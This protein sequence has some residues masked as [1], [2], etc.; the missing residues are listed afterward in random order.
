MD[1]FSNIYIMD[2][3]SNIY[4]MDYFSTI[5]L[6]VREFVI[7]NFLVSIKSLEWKKTIIKNNILFYAF[8]LV[9]FF[10]LKILFKNLDIK[11]IYL[12]D[13]LYFSNYCKGIKILPI[14]ILF[15]GSSENGEKINLLDYFK[16]YS[17]SVPLWFF[18]ENEQLN[19]DIIYVKYFS[20]GKMVE[21]EIMVK[22]TKEELLCDIL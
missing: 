17:S 20:K 15:N 12:M 1:Y 7:K 22:D 6:S 8:K 18:L 21:K 13:N 14:L 11:C 10:I 16:Y 5:F 19:I 4:I 2:Y 9:P 3:F